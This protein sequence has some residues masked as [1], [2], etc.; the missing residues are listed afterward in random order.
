MVRTFQKYTD[1]QR[2]N[3]TPAVAKTGK[4]S[5]TQTNQRYQA[6]A[7]TQ[8][9]PSVLD[10]S[11]SNQHRRTIQTYIAVFACCITGAVHLDLVTDLAAELFLLAFRRFCSWIGQC[12]L[13]HCRRISD[14]DDF[15]RRHHTTTLQHAP[16][17]IDKHSR[18]GEHCT[19]DLPVGHKH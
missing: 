6:I 9:H 19:K 2:K 8:H 1:T 15:G 7:S 13:L 17:R 12:N 14:Q 4:V 11:L 16:N 10:T 5:Y 3:E 18:N